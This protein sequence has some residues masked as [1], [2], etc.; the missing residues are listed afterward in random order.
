MVHETGRKRTIL[1][2]DDAPENL[3]VIKS[4]LV[5][6][7]TVKRAASGAMA[8]KIAES[9]PPDLIL[10]D[11]MMPDMNGYEVCRK[12]KESGTTR[13]IPVIFVTAKD[14][15]E[16]EALGLDMGA[17]DYIAKPIRPPILRARVHTHIVLAD[18]IRQLADQNKALLDAARLRE[19]V[20]H[21]M[22]HDLKG[23]LN[24]IIGAPQF[25]L[26]KNNLLDDQR[27]MIKIIE[28]SGY[29]MLDMINRSL[30][31][32]KMEN[33]IYE[34]RPE[35][36][37][38]V[39]ILHGVMAELASAVS[40]KQLQV[41]IQIDG[42]DVALNQRVDVKAE[43]LLCHSMFSNLCKNAIEASPPGDRLTIHFSRGPDI[44]TSIDNGGDVP[45]DIRPRF[46]DKFVTAGKRQGTGL[47][48]YS[49]MLIARTQNGSITLDA[50]VA[51][52]A[53]RLV[54]VIHDTVALAPLQAVV[55]REGRGKG[56]IVVVPQFEGREAEILL[57]G[58]YA[59]S[60]GLIASVKNM[61]GI[62]AVREL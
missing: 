59:L 26:M 51:K 36:V 17:V 34:F 43:G 2:V 13:D 18:S 55:N 60:P 38:L 49:A 21:I 6:D 22:R 15:T 53:K 57:P 24:V 47:G 29:R 42:Q 1:A 19:D 31:I 40:A 33:G 30:D 3:D 52:T 10:L 12:L 62:V 14:Q 58:R 41:H 4:I 25:L 48:T 20:D 5:P 35:R 27:D 9:Q 39:A 16:D 8:L 45:E 37:D 23:P 56:E 11:I 7:Y 32:F 28:Q 50:A 46:F 44:V 61:P 54:L